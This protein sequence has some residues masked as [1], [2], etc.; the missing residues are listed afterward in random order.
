M[1]G[2]QEQKESTWEH[3]TTKGKPLFLPPLIFPLPFSF[4]F[5]GFFPSFF[6]P[7]TLF[8]LCSL[9]YSPPSLVSQLTDVQ[10]EPPPFINDEPPHHNPH[11]FLPPFFLFATIWQC[12]RITLPFLF[13]PRSAGFWLYPHTYSSILS[14]PPASPS[15]SLSRSISLLCRNPSPSTVIFHSPFPP[16]TV[17]T[18]KT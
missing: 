13:A 2:Q 5:S 4:P 1:R 17:S 12:F 8:L 14:H 11:P 18:V 16:K 9:L 10:E 3:T 15:S 6:I 7:A